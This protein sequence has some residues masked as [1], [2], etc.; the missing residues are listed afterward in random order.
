ME[1]AEVTGGIEQ[2]RSFISAH[3][4]SRF[5]SAW[6]HPGAD[7]MRIPNLAGYRRKTDDGVEYFVTPTAWNEEVTR[8]YNSHS[9][10][11]AMADRGLL[12]P[13]NQR[14]RVKNQ[15]IPGEGLRRV[16]H[17][18]PKLLEG[19]QTEDGMGGEM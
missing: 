4:Q 14:C 11:K 9:L 18:S 1:P 17:I 10:A 8:D 2:V 13:E 6:D 16:Y 3:G 15:R 19:E 5:L 7:Q 12:F